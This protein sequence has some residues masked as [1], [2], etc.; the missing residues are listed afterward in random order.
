[1]PFGKF[2][3]ANDGLYHRYGVIEFHVNGAFCNIK[4]RNRSQ[5]IHRHKDKNP[6]IFSVFVCV[7][8]DDKDARIIPAILT[9]III[10]RSNVAL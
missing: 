8:S 10:Y 3:Q 5:I 4:V 2:M 7:Y 9:K 1:M 6:K